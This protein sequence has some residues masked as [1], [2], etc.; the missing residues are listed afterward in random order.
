MGEPWLVLTLPDGA[1]GAFTRQE[2]TEARA[3]AAELG[4]GTS[5]SVSAPASPE[6]LL[7]SK[8]MAALLDAH[9]TTLEQMARDGRVPSIRIGKLLRFEPAAVIAALRSANTR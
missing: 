4:F 2:L 1:C 5:A 9:D 8:G 6:K 3:R 7:D